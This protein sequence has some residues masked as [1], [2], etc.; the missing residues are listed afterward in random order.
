MK[1]TLRHIVFPLILWWYHREP[2]ES[3]GRFLVPF[4]FINPT[5]D[6][7]EIQIG[8]IPGWRY[9]SFRLEAKPPRLVVSRRDGNQWEHDFLKDSSSVFEIAD[10]GHFVLHRDGQPPFVLCQ[11]GDPYATQLAYV[12]S[13]MPNEVKPRLR[14]SAEESSKP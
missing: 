14:F 1:L 2:R 11:C 10:G 13:A 7:V 6:S 9:G 3:R 4:R 12:W 5:G 8:R